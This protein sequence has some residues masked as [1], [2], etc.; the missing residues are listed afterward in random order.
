MSYR[1]YWQ[2]RGLVRHFSGEVTAAEMLAAVNAAAADPRFDDLRYI[3]DDYL[4]CTGNVANAVEMEEVLAIENAARSFNRR[5]RIAII[6]DQPDVA[7]LMDCYIHGL[8]EKIPHKLFSTRDA[9]M[10]WLNSPAWPSP[11]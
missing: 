3:V 2:P 10:A 6:A 9:A 7:R 1:L 4:D 5:L 11:E 8:P